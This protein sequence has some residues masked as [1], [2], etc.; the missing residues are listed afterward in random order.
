MIPDTRDI[1][2]D[3]AIADLR[4]PLIDP[5]WPHTDEGVH[6]PLAIAEAKISRAETLEA[7]LGRLN[8]KEEMALL[9]SEE[10]LRRVQE[11][12]LPQKVLESAAV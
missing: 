2:C 1:V 12:F 11:R 3:R 10:A 7:Y 6:V 8:A 9:N 5:H 4:A